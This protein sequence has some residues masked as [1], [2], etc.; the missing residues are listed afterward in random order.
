MLAARRAAA[1]AAAAAEDVER[2]E[3]AAETAA[4]SFIS[5]EE[6]LRADEG[7]FDQQAVQPPLPRN[8]DRVGGGASLA[9]VS[10]SGIRDDAGDVPGDDSIL[11]TGDCAVLVLLAPELRS[12]G[13]ATGIAIASRLVTVVLW[14]AYVSDD[15]RPLL[16]ASSV[17]KHQSLRRVLLATMKRCDRG[18]LVHGMGIHALASCFQG[19]LRAEGA[20]DEVPGLGI[21]G[22]D[23]MPTKRSE[24]AHSARS[25]AVTLGSLLVKSDSCLGW[26]T[27]EPLSLFTAYCGDGWSSGAEVPLILDHFVDLLVPL[28][29]LASG[30][31]AERTRSCTSALYRMLPPDEFTRFPLDSEGVADFIDFASRYAA[32]SSHNSA[33]LERALLACDRN[34]FSNVSQ[35]LKGLKVP[36]DGLKQ[37]LRCIGGTVPEYDS[38]SLGSLNGKL[39]RLSDILRNPNPTDRLGLVVRHLGD[40]LREGGGGGGGG[41]GGEGD[42]P[43]VATA[44]TNDLVRRM[45]LLDGDM[46]VAPIREVQ[47]NSIFHFRRTFFD[48]TGREKTSK[49]QEKK[50]LFSRGKCEKVQFR[51]NLADLPI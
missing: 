38:T 15:A 10:A 27:A 5:E 30:T 8:P 39:V 9:S 41:G 46:R 6:L 22:A 49:S 18:G 26:N 20:I 31:V 43:A 23:F 16:A 21:T 12:V 37:A 42:T 1:L 2:E 36:T 48:F 32:T 7:I 51:C 13:A 45:Q 29:P 28:S 34:H 17:L 3:A 35:L 24:I 4:L 11:L 44:A 47:K 50:N 33:F 25:S 40:G 19:V 14:G